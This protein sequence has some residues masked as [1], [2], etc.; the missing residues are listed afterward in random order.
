[1][2]SVNLNIL[3]HH[4]LG[5][6]RIEHRNE[7]RHWM[8]ENVGAYLHPDWVIHQRSSGTGWRMRCDSSSTWFVEFDNDLD[9]VIFKLR[10]S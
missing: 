8:N 4:I 10:F 2:V 3:S 5:H 7:M 9:S 6:K 1:M